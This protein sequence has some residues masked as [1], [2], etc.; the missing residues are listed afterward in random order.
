IPSERLQFIVTSARI[1]L[2]LTQQQT[3]ENLP[4]QHIKRLLLDADWQDVE[5]ES[6]E[7]PLQA[8]YPDNLAYII[9]TSGS[10]GRPKGV[11][12]PHRGLANLAKE[13]ISAYRVDAHSR[14]LL[15]ASTSFDA[16]VV[17]LLMALLSGA[18]LCLGFRQRTRMGTDLLETL[19]EQAIT[20]LDVPPSVLATLDAANLPMIQSVIVAG[21]AAPGGLLARWVTADRRVY[22]AYGP[23]EAT[24]CTTIEVVEPGCYLAP[25]G[26][27][28]AHVQVYI[29]DQQLR[30]V[31]PGV[32]G[33]IVIGGV[34]VVRGYL[35]NPALTSEQ[36]IPDPFSRIPGA[37]LYRT[38]D[39][40]RYLPQG[41]SIFLKRIDDQVKFRGYRIELGE[42]EHVLT[43]H[44]AIQQAAVLLREDTP[45]NQ[46]LVAYLVL[47]QASLTASEV[48]V[49]A[50]ER[51]PE[52]MVP[53]I[54]VTLDALPTTLSGKLDR[55]ALPPPEQAASF[56]ENEERYVAPRS[57]LEEQLAGIWSE[58]LGIER[59]G[60][61][62]N[63]FELGGH[64]LLATLAVSRLQ[65]TFQIEAPLQVFMQRSTVADWVQILREGGWNEE[66]G[67]NEAAIPPGR[68]IQPVPRD[69]E[70]PLS[71]AQQQIW[72]AHQ[73]E[74]GSV[75]YNVFTAF[76]M[77]G[78]LVVSAFQRS[79]AE[80]VRRHEVL[81][82]TFEMGT[83]FPVQHI[84]A[85]IP[86]F[87]PVVDISEL[88]T[89]QREGELMRLATEEANTPFDLRRGPL[90]R[91]VLVRLAQ[92]EHV[93]L[94]TIHHIVTDGWSLALVARELSVLYSAYTQ[95][96]LSPLPEPPIQYADYAAWQHTW[97][98]S[99]E[100]EEQLDF[101]RRHLA[102]APAQLALPT[103]H[104]SPEKRDSR[105]ATYS[106]M[107]STELTAQ[108]KLL[109][110]QEDGTLFITI[111][112]AWLVLLHQQTNQQDIVVGA[113]IAG[114]NYA[115][116]EELVGCFVNTLPLRT[117]FTGTPTFRQMMQQVR[118][119]ALEAFENQNIPFNLLVSKLHPE[120][121]GSAA[122]FFQVLLT[123]HN[124][125]PVELHLADIEI[126][127][128]EIDLPT[129]KYDVV[130]I[131][132]ERENRLRIS[133][134]YNTQLFEEGTITRWAAQF[135]V[136]LK[137][138]IRN[139]DTLLS[140]LRGNEQGDEQISS[141]HQQHQ[142]ARRRT[143]L[144]STRPQEIQIDQDNEG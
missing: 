126:E 72:I 40:A 30:P 87:L 138:V 69:H 122:P 5:L 71:Y 111:L 110:Q 61:H 70:L 34:G 68:L 88:E 24:V 17:E 4:P 52:Y 19:Q 120:R 143:M 2:V 47:R 41:K 129:A 86:I 62:D 137:Q 20:V 114:R 7:L 18:S 59:V 80:I 12:V 83:R 66:R 45:G 84:A 64:S 103:D 94:I 125:R 14:V 16:S 102:G 78:P 107:L 132:D 81:R 134:N 118:Q 115:E 55:R 6:E 53:A 108:L 44:P 9:F 48:R 92:N 128:I 56:L 85:P 109:G 123:F 127:Q 27:A 144:R 135:E 15:F 58:V 13:L 101:W 124:T 140:L 96:L 29:L 32:A 65:E 95:G 36:F 60:I 73:L 35:N 57:R 99:Q 117:R 54:Y 82:T 100:F 98:K 131:I 90:L 76:H 113:S 28:I 26:P 97:L 42:I 141:G 25:L 121:S 104:P 23:T 74:P 89:E 77:R 49:Y 91:V 31:P 22:N 21:E 63:F 79:I 46:R 50:E 136:I 33:E 142:K 75:A 93:A 11:Q 105:G 106:T 37:R 116:M 139:P 130:L 1:K 133:W 38:G 51:L 3:A 10:T 112:A 119:I 43:T 8:V 67:W 39:L